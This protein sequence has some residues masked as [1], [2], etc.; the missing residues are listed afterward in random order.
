[1]QRAQVLIV[2]DEK[3][4]AAD[5]RENLKSLGYNVPAVLSSGEDAIRC[6]TENRPDLVLMDIQLKG[7]IDGIEAA[8][9]VQSRLNVPVVYITAFADDA[10]I[11]RAK[12]TE[13]YGYILK[14]FGKKELQSTIEIALYKHG[15]ER[16]LKTSEQWLMALIRN[17]PEG[18]LAIDR[19]GSVVLMNPGAEI[20]AGVALQDALGADWRDLIEFLD[21]HLASPND[22]FEAARTQGAALNLE[23]TP[24]RFPKTGRK[25]VLLASVAPIQDSSSSAE[26]C[27]MVLRDVTAQRSLDAEYQRLRHL[28][29]LQRLAGGVAHSLNNSLTIISGYSEALERALEPADE[30][31]RDVAMVQQAGE[32]IGSLTR[33]LLSFSRRQPAS[34]RKLN[35]NELV[36]GLE[37]MLR[38]SLGPDIRIT[39]ELEPALGVVEMDPSH[40]EQILMSLA[41]NAGDAMPTGG[42]LTI[43]TFNLA[44]DVEYASRFVDLPAGDYIALEV[45]D[46][47]AGIDYALQPQIFEPFFSTKERGRA[48]L[49]LAAVYG[50]VKQSGGHIWFESEPGRGAVFSVCFPCVAAGE[51]VCDGH[52]SG[53]LRGAETI[54]V[55]ED[56]PEF[57]VF[58]REA[59]LRL[60]YQVIEAASG[61]EAMRICEDASNSIHLVLS[62]VMMPRMSGF[63]LGRQLPSLRPNTKLIF[64]SPYSPYALKH[65]GALEEGSIVLQKPF[66]A[67][68]LAAKVRQVLDD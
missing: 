30:R 67:A 19:F 21:P 29:A 60:G 17:V 7:K 36:G 42:A 1:M 8:K 57:R 41:F 18:V 58:T 43:R 44:V 31:L 24:V 65:H 40:I 12:S 14:P 3:I 5:I 64:M 49:S 28:E 22:P 48:G 25:A 38:H 51:A 26:G 9:I 33:Q 6:A 53:L 4:V 15:R 37:G 61:G 20:I 56:E 10:T 68:T 45:R 32:R 59:L 27:V 39:I 13:P 62:A 54:L 63:E 55:V 35:L 2:E 23:G 34:P 47:G 46:T 52:A 50:I 16:R 66:S 11:Q